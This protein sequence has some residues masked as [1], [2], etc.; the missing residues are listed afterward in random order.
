VAPHAV[1][2]KYCTSYEIS[3]TVFLVLSQPDIV[4][5]NS[6]KVNN[7]NSQEQEQTAYSSLN[8]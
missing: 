6:T 1:G 3:M 2:T 4:G 8:Y 7:N 5:M